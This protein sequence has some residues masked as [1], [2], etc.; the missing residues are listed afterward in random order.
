[1]PPIC[2]RRL[3]P[4]NV[5]S[6]THFS[7]TQQRR[8][9]ACV[10]C[11]ACS[12]GS[13]Q[14]VPPGLRSPT[15]TGP[16]NRSR[17]ACRGRKCQ[18]QQAQSH[19]Q[20]SLMIIGPPPKIYEVRDIIVGRLS[21][22]TRTSWHHGHAAFAAHPSNPL[23][24]WI[25]RLRGCP[26]NGRSCWPR[27]APSPGSCRSCCR[28]VAATAH[29][30]GTQHVAL[31]RRGGA[32]PRRRFSG[33]GHPGRLGLRPRSRLQ[34]SLL[35]VPDCHNPHSIQHGAVIPHANRKLREDHY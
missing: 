28:E 18:N 20:R 34:L 35:I 19:Q 4:A 23:R 30:G 1:M 31:H 15:S 29:C 9:W 6:P 21:P 5:I 13:R 17:T 24:G 22:G 25:Q 8:S 12:R 27:S 33:S 11:W 16:A 7:S 26:R 3:A 14:A 2:T 10:A 32:R